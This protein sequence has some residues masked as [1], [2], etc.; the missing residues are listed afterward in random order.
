MRPLL[1]PVLTPP[2]FPHCFS[3]STFTTSLK[4]VRKWG[5]M[6]DKISLSNKQA[7]TLPPVLFIFTIQAAKAQP[8]HQDNLVLC[9]ICTCLL[10]THCSSK[11]HDNK[12]YWTS[13]AETNKSVNKRSGAE[14]A[15]CFFSPHWLRSSSR[16]NYS[17]RVAAYL[18]LQGIFSWLKRFCLLWS[19]L[20]PPPPG[21]PP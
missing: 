12:D 20:T 16:V 3:S 18:L 9:S 7:S 8:S 2:V 11:M 15:V 19:F 1:A 10:A 17:V 6:W 5:D 13:H 21:H 14:C 4:I